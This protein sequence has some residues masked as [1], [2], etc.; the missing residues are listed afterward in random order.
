MKNIL[1]DPEAFGKLKDFFIRAF[2]KEI[3]HSGV[4]N[5]DNFKN[6]PEFYNHLLTQPGAIDG[7]ITWRKAALKIEELLGYSMYH[8]DFYLLNHFIRC[9]IITGDEESPGDRALFLQEIFQDISRG[10]F[11]DLNVKDLL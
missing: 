2:Y 3:P 8:D 1:E 4:Y 11:K 9:K 6:A 7:N 10:L 5:H